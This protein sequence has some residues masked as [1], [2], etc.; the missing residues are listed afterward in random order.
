MIGLGAAT[1]LFFNDVMLQGPFVGRVLEICKPWK[2][3][4]QNRT[5]LVYSLR[6]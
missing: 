4:C 5:E 3:S 2:K 1:L 6:A